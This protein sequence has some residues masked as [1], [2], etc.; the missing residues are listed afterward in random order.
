MELGMEARQA[1]PGARADVPADEIKRLSYSSAGRG[2]AL[3]G[4][5]APGQ[6]AYP[7]YAT[8]SIA[9]TSEGRI[10]RWQGWERAMVQWPNGE[11]CDRSRETL[12]TARRLMRWR[13]AAEGCLNCARRP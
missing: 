5:L 8:G 3:Q 12:E 13:D 11:R 1:V 10:A 2:P 4:V 6:N 7:R 9:R